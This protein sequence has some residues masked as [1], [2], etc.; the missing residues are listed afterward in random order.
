MWNISIWP[1][2]LTLSDATTPGH[3]GLRSD[4]NEGE[5]CIPQNSY[6]TEASSSDYLVSYPGH[7]LCESYLLCSEA[8]KAHMKLRLSS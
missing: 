6:I 1:I 7:S 2:D 4:A 3:G 5:F 8:V